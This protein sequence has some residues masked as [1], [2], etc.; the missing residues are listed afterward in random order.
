MNGPED[1]SPSPAD[2]ARAPPGKRRTVATAYQA[3]IDIIR[4]AGLAA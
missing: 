4:D 1:L 3:A 2:H